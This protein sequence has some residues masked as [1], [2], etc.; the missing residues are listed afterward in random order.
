VADP[1]VKMGGVSYVLILFG[2]VIFF[3]AIL[4][5]ALIGLIERRRELATY[6][7]IGYQPLEIGAMLLRETLLV[8]AVGILPAC[9]WAGGCWSA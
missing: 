2:A 6:R 4:N 3:G 1:S 5:A 7:V 9:R 8:N